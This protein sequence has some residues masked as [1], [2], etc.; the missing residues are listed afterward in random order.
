[1]AVKWNKESFVAF[2]EKMHG[3]KYEY[4][5][6]QYITTQQK[7]EI[8]CSEHGSFYQTPSNHMKGQGCPECGRKA[9]SIS[10]RGN[11]EAFIKAAEEKHGKRYNYSEV[12]Y[13]NTMTKVKVTCTIHGA[14]EVRPN[15]HL[16]GNGCP[17]CGRLSAREN[18]ALDYSKFIERAEKVHNDRYR[19][20]TE[21]YVNY[22][23]KMSMFCFE[24]GFF[25]QTPHSHISMKVGCPKCGNARAGLS[26]Q[27]DWSTVLELFRSVHGNRFSYDNSMYKDV[28][29]KIK[30]KCEKHGWFEQKPYQHY[31]GAGCS[32]CSNEEVHESQKIGFEE[33]VERSVAMH[34]NKYT[35]D[36]D[37]F[38]DIFTPI[39]IQCAKHGEFIQAPRDHYR[40]SG[41][42]KCLS[43]R[44]EREI[45]LILERLNVKFEEQKT[46]ADLKH[47]Y[48]LR[49]DFYLP[50]LNAVIEY[51]G[52]Q[53]YEPVSIF[54]GE[55][56]LID[57][58]FRDKLKYE[59][60]SSKGIRLIIIRFDDENV[61]DILSVQL[62]IK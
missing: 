60:L 44:G 3:F 46:F 52:I 51:N 14:F 23:S 17:A 36:T 41:C 59:F 8:I 7:V 48:K 21:S 42:T 45:R 31:G 12:L 2:A 28:S 38:K 53:H 16:N 11:V 1:M 13:T 58:Q 25:S 29:H 20:I 6:I 30:V 47:K 9:R 50:K 10:Q 19:Y 32:K 54:G 40:G 62:G 35:Y 24:H 33:F 61:E 26:N 34:G 57:N 37:G 56:G 49:C 15:S 27:K 5:K 55:Q 22:T 39:S 4:S 18:I 43:S